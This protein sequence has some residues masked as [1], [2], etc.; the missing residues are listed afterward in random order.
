MNLRNLNPAQLF[1]LRKKVIQFLKNGNSTADAAQIFSLNVRQI[2][3]I[4]AAYLAAGE[5][6]EK[7]RPQACGRK[8]ASGRLLEYSETQDIRSDLITSSPEQH[9][10]NFHLWTRDTIIRLIEKKHGKIVPARSMTNYLK[11]W[12][13]PFPLLD[14]RDGFSEEEYIFLKTHSKKEHATLYRLHARNIA[15]IEHYEMKSEYI[16]MTTRVSFIP[17]EK[18]IDA[19]YAIP[20]KGPVRFLVVQDRNK[21]NRQIDFLRRLMEDTHSAKTIVILDNFHL[22]DGKQ[23]KKFLSRNSNRLEVIEIPAIPQ[24]DLYNGNVP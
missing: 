7:L 11:E 20:S 15:Q 8:K 13:L 9:G 6:I 18:P 24:A 1:S 17:A 10:L 14:W 12:R 19:I 23:I 21:Q 16:T 4:W 22:D 5:D 2:E 3:K